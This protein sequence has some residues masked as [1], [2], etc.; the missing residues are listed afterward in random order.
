MNAWLLRIGLTDA[1][2]AASY[3][4]WNRESSNIIDEDQTIA[5]TMGED[6]SVTI[7]VLDRDAVMT[8]KLSFDKMTTTHRILN[9]C[10][11]SNLLHNQ[12]YLQQLNVEV[13]S[14]E[15]VLALIGG[16]EQT[17]LD[18]DELQRSVGYFAETTDAPVH[19]KICILIH[20]FRYN[21]TNE[22]QLTISHRNIT[23]ATLL[24][25]IEH[26]DD[27]KYLA[28]HETK[29]VFAEN[30][31][32][33]RISETT[34]I[35]AKE[36]HTCLVSID[37]SRENGERVQNHRYLLSATIGDIH[38]QNR[39]LDQFRSLLYGGDFV[40]SQDTRLISFLP[41]TTESIAFMLIP[42]NL[43]VSVTITSDK[44]ETSIQLQCAS[45]IRIGRLTEIVC[46]IWKL[47]QRFY[48][49]FHIDDYQVDDD[50][51]LEEIDD[52][53]NEFQLKL[54]CNADLACSVTYK[55]RT[56]HLPTSNEVIALTVLQEAL[57]KFGMSLSELEMFELHVLDDT[58]CSISIDPEL[59]VEIIRS[60]LP[61]EPTL[62]PFQLQRKED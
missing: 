46:R 27:E 31:N 30:T 7:D 53:A 37:R 56:V 57:Q 12:R 55:D 54:V 18:S 36:D 47:N 42:D 62:I 52:S 5:S 39:S 4:F 28:S 43:P 10:P 25:Q 2:A 1:T 22:Q 50:F 11:L 20:F 58:E 8:I 33:S 29:I 51:T 17:I 59:S 44:Q 40:P 61:G 24:G 38:K 13:S 49:L 41:I 26:D 45:S 48:G 15:L 6:P 9:S 14:A 3:N 32:L 34:F 60:D 23:V 21:D 16:T 19:F 35:L